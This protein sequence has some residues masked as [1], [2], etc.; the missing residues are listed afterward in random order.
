MACGNIVL[1][2]TPGPG[3]N[4]CTA[5]RFGLA[6]ALFEKV[7]LALPTPRCVYGGPKKLFSIFS[8]MG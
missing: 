7:P 5:A 6:Q 3:Q 1:I 2:V 8:E 4:S